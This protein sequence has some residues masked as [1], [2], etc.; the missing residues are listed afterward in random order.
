MPH[1]AAP[2]CLSARRAPGRRGQ[3]H[4]P[5]R[6]AWQHGR[7]DR[8]DGSTRPANRQRQSS[9]RW[10]PGLGAWER[11]R[12]QHP[13]WSRQR[14]TQDTPSAPGFHCIAGRVPLP[15]AVA[16]RR[17]WLGCRGGGGAGGAV[18]RQ[19]GAPGGVWPGEPVASAYLGGGGRAAAQPI[20]GARRAQTGPCQHNWQ[21]VPE[22]QER[23][24]SG[25]DGEGG[26]GGE[27]RSRGRGR[28]GSAGEVIAVEENPASR[29]GPTLIGPGHVQRRPLVK[30]LVIGALEP[31]RARPVRCIGQAQARVDEPRSEYL[32]ARSPPGRRRHSL[33]LYFGHRRPASAPAVDIFRAAGPG[34]GAGTCRA[35][36]ARRTASC[37]PGVAVQPVTTSIPILA[38]PPP[39]ILVLPAPNEKSTSIPRITF[40]LPPPLHRYDRRA[41][42]ALLPVHPP[43]W[44]TPK[45]S[46][47]SRARASSST[48]PPTSRRTSPTCAPTTSRRCACWA[49]RWASRPAGCWARCSPPRRT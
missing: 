10:R 39:Y 33:P 14:A 43:Q 40:A 29:N 26:G 23:P 44:P 34:R 47:P 41:R 20:E 19:A 22:P 49:T 11:P 1:G 30:S 31:R 21:A 48:R 17:G 15:A 42:L 2:W 12:R 7:R 37:I 27:V 35:G 5:P 4:T 8:R 16:G 32:P 6:R 24:Q 25:H 45:R 46:S 18:P 9:R 36:T 13:S 3:Q 28:K 38:P